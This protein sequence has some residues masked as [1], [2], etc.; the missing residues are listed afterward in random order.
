MISLQGSTIPGIIVLSSSLNLLHINGEA[1]HLLAGIDGSASRAEK[2]RTLASPLHAQ[3]QEIIDSMR[4]RLAL[5]DFNLFYCYRSIRGAEREILSKGFGL[6]D[7][8]GLPHSRIVLL[9]S[10]HVPS[11][12]PE[13]CSANW[14]LNQS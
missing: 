9:L 12:R 3:C 13:R 1:L 2:Q 14:T 5:S 6:L 11:S 10:T 8:R 4:E 7:R